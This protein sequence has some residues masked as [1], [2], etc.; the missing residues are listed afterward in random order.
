MTA[1]G[2]RTEISPKYSTAQE[3]ED[4][5]IL[6]AKEILAR[7]VA[8]G[9]LITNPDTAY[10]YLRL[11]LGGRETEAFVV[12]YLNT[13]HKLISA[14]IVSEGTLNAAT[15]F[16]REILKR[17]LSLNAAAVILA[18]NHPSGDLH[19]SPTDIKI[20]KKLQ[21]ALQLIEVKTLDHVLVTAGGSAS[22]KEEGL[23]PL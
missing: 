21:D 1:N 10:S 14:E 12:L 7:R 17:V 9:P 23:L 22:M 13:A 5:I 16:P 6:H 15:V 18:H 19:F 3:A 11:W 4:K 8:S 2:V 20:T